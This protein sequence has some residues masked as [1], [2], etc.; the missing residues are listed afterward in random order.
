MSQF[1]TSYLSLGS[2]L[3]DK[4][5]NLENAVKA[6]D[7]SIATVLS[8][9]G[10]YE[11]QAWGFNGEDF[12]NICIKIK[13]SLNPENLLNQL[14]ALEKSLGRK[15]KMGTDYENRSI[16]VDIILFHNEKRNSKDL[17][18]PHPRAI[19][20]KFVL[21]PLF[22]IY[23]ENQPPFTMDSL[24]QNIKDCK[25]NSPISKIALKLDFNTVTQ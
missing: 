25:D 5:K 22:D 19:D 20:R 7:S 1:Y 3:N 11:T 15:E 16:D 13:T 8:V 6:I 24:E 10:I 23:D 9:S 21:L 12:Y 18:L 14:L 4:F 17:Q 2:N